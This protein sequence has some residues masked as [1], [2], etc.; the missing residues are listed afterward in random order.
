MPLSLFFVD[1]FSFKVRLYYITAFIFAKTKQELF[2]VMKST[3]VE[4][5]RCN[6]YIITESTIKILSFRVDKSK[7]T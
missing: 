5:F 4:L 1:L 2:F 6:T 3:S 7:Q